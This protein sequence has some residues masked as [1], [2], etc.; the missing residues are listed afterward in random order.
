MFSPDKHQLNICINTVK[1]GGFPSFLGG[2]TYEE[3]IYILKK[4][5]GYSNKKIVKIIGEEARRMLNGN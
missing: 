5:F 1:N 3:A 4:K 2:P